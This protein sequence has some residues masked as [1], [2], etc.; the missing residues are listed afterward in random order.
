MATPTSSPRAPRCI[1][2]IFSAPRSSQLTAPMLRLSDLISNHC[3]QKSSRCSLRLR[4]LL[5]S[6]STDCEVISTCCTHPR[7]LV[8]RFIAV[9]VLY[10]ARPGYLGRMVGHIPSMIHLTGSA[11]TSVSGW[12]VGRCISSQV[13]N[14]TTVQSQQPIST[15]SPILAE[16]MYEGDF[17]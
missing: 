13:N 3:H 15:F 1:I 16:Y 11:A 9:I 2:A 10:S 12:H 5:P 7:W 14:S 8:T 6:Y 4:V 17:E